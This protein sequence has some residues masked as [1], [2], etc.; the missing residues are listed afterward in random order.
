MIGA[1]ESPGCLAYVPSKHSPCLHSWLALHFL[2]NFF[3]TLH[4]PLPLLPFLW[5]YKPC[6][7]NWNIQTSRTRTTIGRITHNG[8]SS[9]NAPLWVPSSCKVQQCRTNAFCNLNCAYILSLLSCSTARF[10][11]ISHGFG[12]CLFFGYN[13]CRCC[14]LNKIFNDYYTLINTSSPADKMSGRFWRPIKNPETSDTIKWL[15]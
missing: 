8:H 4:F 12:K 7:I 5:Q 15:K 10:V 14:I 6:L 13:L 3:R 2:P 9:C 1:N 11:H